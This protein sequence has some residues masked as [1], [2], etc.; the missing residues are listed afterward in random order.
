M[1]FICAR[2]LRHLRE[3]NHASVLNL[4]VRDA[5]SA[6]ICEQ[7]FLSQITQIL[8]DERQVGQIDLLKQMTQIHADKRQIPHSGDTAVHVVCCLSAK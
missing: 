3:N 4:S 7:P 6:L 5:Y 8:A 2:P 1:S